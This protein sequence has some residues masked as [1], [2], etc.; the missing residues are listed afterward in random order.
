MQEILQNKT[1]RKYFWIITISLLLL[2]TCFRFILFENVDTT[3]PQFIVFLK[4]LIEEL[5]AAIITTTGIG[6]FIFY[7]APKADPRE[8]AVF[9]SSHEFKKYFK[10]VLK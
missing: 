2:L 8:G 6:A 9:L 3:S 1:I 7:I 10:E 4:D 5:I